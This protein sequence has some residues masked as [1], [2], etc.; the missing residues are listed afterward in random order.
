MLVATSL[1]LV[2]LAVA[3][4]GQDT[5]TVVVG[6]EGSFYDPPT[7]DALE[8]DKIMFLFSGVIHGVTQSSFDA[9]CS[10]LQGGF[11][12]GLTGTNNTPN[13]PIPVWELTISN[14][15]ETIWFFCEATQPESHCQAGMVG[16]INPPSVS[17]FN[18]FQAAAKSVSGTPAP[19]PTVILTGIGA[20]AT[21]GPIMTAIPSSAL[22]LISSASPTPSST[23]VSSSA[24][25]SASQSSSKRT[26]NSAVI[27]GAVGGGVGVVVLEIRTADA[28]EKIEY[29]GPHA[30]LPSSA[31]STPNTG[32]FDRGLNY[33]DA[34]ARVRRQ[35]SLNGI[36]SATGRNSFTTPSD[37]ITPELS[38][39]Y[40]D[41]DRERD[42]QLRYA[43]SHPGMRLAA[44]MVTATPFSPY[45]HSHA[46]STEQV[47]TNR[48]I[49]ERGH[50][51]NVHE[52]AKEVAALIG[53]QDRM[54]SNLPPSVN[55]QPA[56]VTV[57]I[58]PIPQ[59]RIA[60]QLPNPQEFISPRDAQTP[61][62][63][64]ALPRYER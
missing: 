20:F 50:D 47:H 10:P 13:A 2:G 63:D 53:T 30:K 9:P 32:V 45:G 7:T 27:G 39:T 43:D 16:A 56:F 25:P 4:A 59:S 38:G 22:S 60:R 57:P 12:S 5:H 62:R 3:T 36:S 15:S 19:T 46:L 58:P 37:R 28:D 11:S 29:S 64:S 54:P 51:V 35:V 1:L 14:V 49:L 41:V 48:Q 21:E 6:L 33:N 61:G 23:M 42:M 26:A 17:M 8:G 44:T 34:D 55:N 52:L 31:G 40:S 24:I 18:Q